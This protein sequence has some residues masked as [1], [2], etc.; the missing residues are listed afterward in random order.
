MAND[1][2]TLISPSGAPILKHAARE[3]PFEIA[4]GSGDV[5]L[6]EEHISRRFGEV[7]FVYHEILSDLVHVDVHHIPPAASRPWHTLVTTGMSDRPMV[8]PE[9]LE[10]CRYA[11]LVI[12]LPVD[13]PLTEQA[14]ED[15]RNYWPIRL[16]KTL[17]RFPHEYDTYLWWGHTVDH[18]DPAEA[19]HH[20]V[21]FRTAC[22]GFPTTV[23]SQYVTARCSDDKVV[24]FFAVYPLFDEE[25]QLKM[26]AGAE[27]LFRRF[28]KAAITEMVNPGRRNV[29]KRRWWF[30]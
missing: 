11:E 14:L 18:G 27:E 4:L 28:E 26:R 19:Y 15:E 12:T 7:D 10:Q 29:A 20:S 17:A 6:L 23:E 5:E 24:T 1:T 13:W 8:V 21:P 9:G 3:K 22:L 16:L 25:V 30:F 2:E